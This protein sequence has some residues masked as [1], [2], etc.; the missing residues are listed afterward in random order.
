MELDINFIDEQGIE[1]TRT[2][3]AKCKEEE[4]PLI[5]SQPQPNKSEKQSQR[6]Q[7][8]ITELA[9]V[10][11]SMGG[12]FIGTFFLTLVICSV[13]ATAVLSGAQVG[14]WQVAIVCGLGVSISIYCTAHVCDAHLNPAITVAFAVVRYK[15]FSWKKIIPY[16]VFQILGGVLAGGVLYAFSNEIISLYEEKNGI[17]RG[18]NASVI[19]AMI[20]GEYFPNPAI[21]NHSNLRN[22]QIVSVT[23]A[24]FVEAWTTFILAF[25]I[26]SLTD[27]NNTTA[28]NHESGR[29]LVPLLIG[30]TVAVLISIYAPLTQVGMNPA[31]DLGPRIVAA[32]A[33]WG[34]VAI[35][36]TR[37]GFW[38]YVLGPVIGALLG[39]ALNDFCVSKVLRLVKKRN[40]SDG[41]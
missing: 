25:V 19:T 10:L 17:T 6:K 21:Y 22:L 30:L 4:E 33:G 5:T 39:G 28:G 11:T 41:E 7:K 31:R 3:V 23:R 15:A 32:C 29:V 38:V 14:L 13:V 9:V 40:L 20:F 18:E 2:M 24:F 26:F 12:E 37:N 36:G 8:F 27:K 1:S 16:I 34:A 35:P